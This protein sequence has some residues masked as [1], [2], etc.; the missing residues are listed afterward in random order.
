MTEQQ[1]RLAVIDE[2]MTWIRTPYHHRAHIK[3]VGV[4]CAQILLEVYAFTGVCDRIDVGQYSHD[5]HMHHS[6][7]LYL[8][9]ITTQCDQ[10]DEPQPGDIALFRFGRCVSHSAIV[11]DWPGKLVHAYIKKGVVMSAADDAEL[12]GRLHSFWS[13]RGFRRS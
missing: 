7:E 12:R 9:W 1:L 6:D 11:V 3:G 4:D 10:V 2:A 13:P 5:W 8:R